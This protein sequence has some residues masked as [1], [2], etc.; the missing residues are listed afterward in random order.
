MIKVENLKKLGL[1]DCKIVTFV[2]LEK[3]IVKESEKMDHQN[4]GF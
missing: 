2:S 4:N 1:N 3:K